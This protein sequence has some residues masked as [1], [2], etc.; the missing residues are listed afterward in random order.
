MMI[1]LV[2]GA[3]Y[4]F[5][6]ELNRSGLQT[7]RSKITAA[8]LAQ[9]KAAVL[10]F[11]LANPRMPG[12][13]PF[14]DRNSDGNYDGSGDCYN[15]ATGLD[16]LLG[17]FPFHTEN[18]C[19]PVVPAFDTIP[20]DAAGERLWYAAAR[21]LLR[22]N[23]GNYPVITTTTLMAST[24]WLSVSD[25]SGTLLS[26]PVAF[27][28]LAPGQ[29]LAGQDRSGVK[30][31]A[32]N[33]LDDF[34]VGAITY[35]NWNSA[36]SLGFIA[37][38]PVNG[39]ANRFNDQLLYVTRDEFLSRLVDRVAGEIRSRLTAYR[40]ANIAYPLGLASVASLPAWFGPDW[41][42]DTVY[43][44][45]NQNRATIQFQ[46]CMGATFTVIWNATTNQSEMLRN[47]R[48]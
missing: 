8:A 6:S 39:A 36:N 19:L 48:C 10:G 30:P 37:A 44:L 1:V 45:V 38:R 14:P 16:L 24:D 40:Q 13:L 11:A 25:E 5:V 21:N 15:G 43:T 26:N 17:K 12:G 47:G 42:A 41:T 29:V 22:S 33:F 28:L 20:L 7:E 2:L 3:S 46:G 31:D 23:G 27:V 35:Q 18:G 34:T 4:L 32:Q 9:A